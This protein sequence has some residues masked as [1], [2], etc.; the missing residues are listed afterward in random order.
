MKA[1]LAIP[2]LLAVGASALPFSIASLP[3]VAG[4]RGHG[5]A[6]RSSRGGAGLAAY[7]RGSLAGRK[8]SAVNGRSLRAPGVPVSVPHFRY[9]RGRL[10]CE[11][12]KRQFQ[13][14]KTS[15][16]EPSA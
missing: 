10:Y 9:S 16:E 8:I 2:T 1:P 3:Q 15:S 4:E 12:E 11:Y 6:V 5:N 13:F 7:V 14:P